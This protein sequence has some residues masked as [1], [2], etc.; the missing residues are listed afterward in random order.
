MLTENRVYYFSNHDN[1]IHNLKDVE[2]IITDTKSAV[3]GKD[4]G[5]D[6]FMMEDEVTIYTMDEIV[7]I[8][9]AL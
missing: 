6:G 5:E 4:C 9:E 1:E 3:I 2:H 8:I 7:K